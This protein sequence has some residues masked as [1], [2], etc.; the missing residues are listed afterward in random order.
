MS[1]GKHSPLSGSWRQKLNT[2]STT[3]AELVGVNDSMHAIIWTRNFL[4]EQGFDIKDNV[5]YQ[6]NQSAM[7]L[8]RNGRA[9]SGQRTRHVNIR[10]FFVADRIANKELR[11]EYCPTDDMWGDFMTNKTLQGSKFKRM[12]AK[13][14]NLSETIALPLTTAASQECVGKP[15]YAEMVRG[16]RGTLV[17][18]S[19]K[20][21]LPVTRPK[22]LNLVHAISVNRDMENDSKSSLLESNL[23]RRSVTIS[24]L[25]P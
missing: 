23:M 5:V 1:L 25:F 20:D 8:E 18:Q 9:S 24:Q 19:Q 11:V 15:S 7:L 10:Y 4:T 3:K 12:R 2:K 13:I 16:T 14:L 17:T 6:D 21:G 22:A